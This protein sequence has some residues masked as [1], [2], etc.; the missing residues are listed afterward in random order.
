MEDEGYNKLEK[1]KTE[2]ICES[3]NPPMCLLCLSRFP[4]PPPTCHHQ[5]ACQAA[6]DTAITYIF[7]DLACGKV[8]PDRPVFL[9]SPFLCLWV[10]VC[11]SFQG[12]EW[13]RKD[14]DPVWLFVCDV[15]RGSRGLVRTVSGFFQQNR[16][17]LTI[18]SGI[19]P[20]VY[21][22]FPTLPFFPPMSSSVCLS[23]CVRY[24]N[25]LHLLWP[26][27]CHLWCHLWQWP[28]TK[29]RW[30]LTVFFLRFFILRLFICECVSISGMRVV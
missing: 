26:R 28:L 5:C 17:Y 19:H 1:I 11:V 21:F 20:C 3:W 24:S 27:L 2:H 8:R 29:P 22:V 25:H 13:L 18:K 7:C 9:I 15:F 6:W 14:S 12:C 16:N 4:V 23:G 30:G 10:C